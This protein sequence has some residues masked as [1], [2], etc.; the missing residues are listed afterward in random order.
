MVIK[1][2]RGVYGYFVIHLL[3]IVFLVFLYLSMGASFLFSVL[4]QIPL[5][6]LS[7]LYFISI[8]RTLYFDEKG[9]TIQLL[10]YKKAIPWNC[11]KYIQ[12]EAY[13]GRSTYRSPY[14]KAILFST[15]KIHKQKWLK[16]SVYGLFFPISFFYVYFLPSAPLE[17]DALHPKY[18][19]E[20]CCDE[21]FF[22][23]K[24]REWNIK[25]TGDGTKPLRISE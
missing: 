17:T 16:P 8:G 10:R 20:F 25:C 6:I 14:D 21:Q 9:C 12:I 5:M 3:I 2:E 7:F 24:L 11:L 13:P 23:S 1:S 18:P 22:M 19:L 4:Y 15:R